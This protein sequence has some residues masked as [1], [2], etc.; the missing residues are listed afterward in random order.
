[1]KPLC[2]RGGPGRLLVWKILESDGEVYKPQIYN[3]VCQE[4]NQAGEEENLRVLYV[5]M[6]RAR[7]KLI[8]SASGSR[9]EKGV[10]SVS[11][12]LKTF[13]DRYNLKKEELFDPAIIPSGYLTL[14]DDIGAPLR[15]RL[16]RE[17]S[18]FNP[19]TEGRKVRHSSAAP[20][21]FP[22]PPE[23]GHDASFGGRI[24]ESQRPLSGGFSGGG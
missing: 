2:L 7:E 21:G 12:W 6:T 20:T 3:T 1:M 13:L 18:V 17:A 5:A 11:G 8:L 23:A 22:V 19:S 15:Y 9:S 24:P 10:G 14:G 16:I 4:K